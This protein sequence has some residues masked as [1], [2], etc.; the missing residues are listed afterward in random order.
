MSKIAIV[1]GSEGDIGKEI[2]IRLREDS[3]KVIGIDLKKIF[4]ENGYEHFYQGSVLD[5]ELIS[6]CFQRIENLN[7]SNLVLVNN[8]GVTF[9]DGD[10][11]KVWNLTLDVNLKAPF[12]WMEAAATFFEKSRINGSIISITSLAAELAFP[13]NPAY[14]AAKG[15]LKQLTKSFAYRLGPLGVSC[16][17]VVPGY[18]ETKFNEKSLQDPLKYQTRAQRSLLNRWGKASEIADAVQ[19]LTSEKSRFITG[20]DI[21]VDGGWTTQGLRENPCF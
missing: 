5:T 11:E 20:Q 6:E 17:N 16:N 1:T 8:A 14:A 12:F 7:V 13:G 3:F 19:F 4:P 2:S 15:G 10:H 9:P 18:I 21:V